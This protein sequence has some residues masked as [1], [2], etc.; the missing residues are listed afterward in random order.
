MRELVKLLTGI[1]SRTIGAARGARRMATGRAARSE[2]A[3]E[4]IV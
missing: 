1:D 3:I 4:A 2:Q